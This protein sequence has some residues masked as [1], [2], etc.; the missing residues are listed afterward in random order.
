MI[1]KEMTLKDY[2]RVIRKRHGTVF[3]FFIATFIVVV[4]GTLSATPK[5]TATT[6]LLIK[7]SDQNP[8]LMKNTY[9]RSDPNFLETQSQVINSTSV[10]NRVVKL[11]GLEEKYDFFFEP[12][13]E[14]KG[15][16]DSTIKWLKNLSSVF[17]NMA[18][19]GLSGSPGDDDK[20]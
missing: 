19:I 6:K 15:M 3:T 1:K 2:Y 4:M 9:V 10:C 20:N 11:L 18:G 14:N 13:R 7:R 12:D 16:I 17:I 8:L 5:Y